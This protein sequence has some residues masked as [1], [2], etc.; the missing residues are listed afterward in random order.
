LLH[1]AFSN[2]FLLVYAEGVKILWAVP[3]ICALTMSAWAQ[4]PSAQVP[5]FEDY[6]VKESWQG[7]R[8]P[9]NLTTRSERMFRTRLTNAA[10]ETPNFA[11]HYRFA[12]WGCGS[13]CISGAVID[14]QAGTVLSP[15]LATR[16]AH[17]SVCQSAYE[18]SGVDYRLDSRLIIVR[19]GLNYSERLDQNVP[20]AY[21]FLLE[22]NRFRQI[23]HLSGKRSGP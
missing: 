18:N 16:V 21:Y 7:M 4:G 9:L 10:K 13:E 12:T 2:S 3:L 8:T 17:F 15:P 20:D 23:L 1:A 5:R 14:L 6:P 19:C 22:D 11:G